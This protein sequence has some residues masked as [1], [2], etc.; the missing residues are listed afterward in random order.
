MLN[1]DGINLQHRVNEEACKQS[2]YNNKI[3]AG[4]V[5]CVFPLSLLK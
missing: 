3:N 5:L 2:P 1:S 4:F